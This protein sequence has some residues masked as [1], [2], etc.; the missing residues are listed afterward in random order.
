MHTQMHKAC[1]DLLRDGTIHSDTVPFN[2][3]VRRASCRI[4]LTSLWPSVRTRIAA[5][6]KNTVSVLG[7]GMKPMMTNLPSRQRGDGL[8][9]NEV[10]FAAVQVVILRERHLVRE[11]LA[12]G[13]LIDRQI[14]SAHRGL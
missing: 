10:L 12:S 6:L 9:A 14:H 5:Q 4:A 2:E 7:L 1:S 8:K 13:W 11:G 3:A